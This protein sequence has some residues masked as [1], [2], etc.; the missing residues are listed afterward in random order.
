MM[1]TVHV[2]N[3][4]GSALINQAIDLRITAGN[5]RR[6]FHFETD[7]VGNIFIAIDQPQNAHW[8][9]YLRSL[10]KA[11][12]AGVNYLTVAG[13]QLNIR[14]AAPIHVHNDRPSSGGLTLKPRHMAIYNQD[15]H[16]P[17]AKRIKQN[18]NSVYILKTPRMQEAAGTLEEIRRSNKLA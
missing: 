18:M 9:T 8:N 11:I 7:R 13:V 17:P 12:V 14:Q 5:L 16:S 1:K 4:N 15:Q 2:T 10:P 3:T 6:I